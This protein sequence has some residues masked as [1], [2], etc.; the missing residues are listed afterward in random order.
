MRLDQVS[1]GMCTENIHL[2]RA[3]GVISIPVWL[4]HEESEFAYYQC[5]RVSTWSPY[6][7]ESRSGIHNRECFTKIGGVGGFSLKV[8]AHIH[9][10]TAQRECA[11]HWHEDVEISSFSRSALEEQQCRRSGYDC[12]CLPHTPLKLAGNVDPPLEKEFNIKS[13]IAIQNDGLLDCEACPANTVY[14]VNRN[15]VV[16]SEYE[17]RPSRDQHSFERRRIFSHF[18]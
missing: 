17:L 9:K 13:N 12:V 4:A 8:V 2:D 7:V 18:Y 6:S 10:V 5:S 3:R 1:Y 15:A 16:K 14:I 11:S